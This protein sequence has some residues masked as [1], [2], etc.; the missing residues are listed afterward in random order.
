MV[1]PEGYQQIL[2][3]QRRIE[4]QK[5]EME[6]L[7]RESIERVRERKQTKQNQKR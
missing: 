4:K 7:R 2:G 6:E 1:N 3:R 5:K